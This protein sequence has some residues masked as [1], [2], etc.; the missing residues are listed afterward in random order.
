MTEPQWRKVVLATIVTNPIWLA[1][2]PGRVGGHHWLLT[3]EC[4]HERVNQL[5][6][7]I[8]YEP[9][10]L[11]ELEKTRAPKRALCWTCRS[12]DDERCIRLKM[13]PF[14]DKQAAA[15]PTGE[16]FPTKFS[17]E[18]LAREHTKEGYRVVLLLPS[19][20]TITVNTPEMSA[21]TTLKFHLD[22]CVARG[23]ITLRPEPELLAPVGP[24]AGVSGGDDEDLHP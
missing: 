20:G 17:F 22:S 21:P 16:V 14:S 5:T 13:N 18:L 23:E 7:K 1:R 19:T 8:G 24:A 6:V 9:D 10:K 12:N 3:L 2:V 15:Q 4:G 11:A